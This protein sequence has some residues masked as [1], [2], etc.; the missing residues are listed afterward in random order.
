METGA[1]VG[2]T[3]ERVAENVKK[4][5]GRIPVRELSRRLGD[6]GRP[7]LPSAITKIEQGTRRVDADDLIALAIVLDVTPN[8]LLLMD[9]EQA[10]EAGGDVDL[11][12]AKRVL[13]REAWEW[14]TG[15]Q[16]LDEIK[17]TKSQYLF[18]LENRPH[19]GVRQVLLEVPGDAV[20]VM[21]AVDFT[22]AGDAGELASRMLEVL[23]D[24]KRT[25]Q[26]LA[27]PSSDVLDKDNLMGDDQKE[28][29]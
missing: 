16:T 6:L 5:R 9:R 18:A 22:Q 19:S 8:R 28:T 12:P 29:R 21:F 15:E 23:E 2:T 17:T 25:V 1:K 3:G 10:V 14:A 27:H 7:M 11:V 13:W 20:S 24:A 26:A 4:L